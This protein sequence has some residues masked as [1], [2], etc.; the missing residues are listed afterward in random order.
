MWPLHEKINK[1][2]AKLRKIDL[3]IQMQMQ[4]AGGSR[5]VEIRSPVEFLTPGKQAGGTPAASWLRTRPPATG[6]AI[7]KTWGGCAQRNVLSRKT[8]LPSVAV[9]PVFHIL[10]LAA[11]GRQWG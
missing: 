10:S 6:L 9:S 1:N 8:E 3:R 11:C 2:T 4:R 7:G 5:P